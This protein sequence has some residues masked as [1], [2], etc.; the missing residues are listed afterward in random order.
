MAHSHQF[1][2]LLKINQTPT[3]QPTKV[4]LKVNKQENQNPEETQE[5]KR[6]PRDLDAVNH[7]QYRPLFPTTRSNVVP[8]NVT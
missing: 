1:L 2:I 4:S 3:R 8:V 6:V 5:D 7:S